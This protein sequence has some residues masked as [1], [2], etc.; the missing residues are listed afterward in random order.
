LVH[1]VL[2]VPQKDLSKDLRR[3]AHPP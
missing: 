2:D 1:P 3:V